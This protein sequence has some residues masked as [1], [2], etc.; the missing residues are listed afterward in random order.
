MK[1]IL[2]LT[3]A[4]ALLAVS[5]ANSADVYAPASSKDPITV[6]NVLPVGA[7]VSVGV[8]G[9]ITDTKFS[10]GF[11]IGDFGFAGFLG[12]V[13][14]GYDMKL[15]NWVVGPI[16]GASWEDV[17][18]N[19]G[20]VTGN[21]TF[22]YEIG[23]RLGYVVNGDALIYGLV[24]Y[25]G[26]HIGFNNTGFAN[27]LYGVKLGGGLEIDMKNGFFLFSEVDDIL[28]NNWTPGHSLGSTVISNDEIRA[29]AGIGKRF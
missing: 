15:G 2:T 1:R 4:A 24:A 11:N 28:Y 21:Q 13:R 25:Q 14:F 20:G 10:N 7:Y 29:L 23:A 27:D 5:P 17:K 16:V 26:Q 12:Q 19:L 8:G 3:A 9:G 18:G 6:A 22:G